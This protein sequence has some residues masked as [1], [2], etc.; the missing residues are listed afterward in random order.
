[1]RKSQIHS[2]LKRHRELSNAFY[3]GLLSVILFGLFALDWVIRAAET[4]GVIEVIV[5]VISFGIF[6]Q[7]I[8]ATIE[9]KKMLIGMEL[10]P[11][12]YRKMPTPKP[13][14]YKAVFWFMPK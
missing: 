4:G 13:I 6:A 1:M 10:N 8:L 7:S 14:L 11:S 2:D 9:A 5:A 3:T 12:E